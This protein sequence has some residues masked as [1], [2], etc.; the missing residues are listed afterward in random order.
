VSGGVL[1]ES[2]RRCRDGCERDEGGAAAG[3]HATR[4]RLCLPDG[5]QLV[6]RPEALE[7]TEPRS[8]LIGKVIATYWPPRRLR[9]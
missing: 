2:K 4:V 9:L 8:S 6:S 5:E 3:L 7:R 1:D